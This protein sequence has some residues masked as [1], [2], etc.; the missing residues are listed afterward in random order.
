MSKN[1]YESH[2]TFMAPSDSDSTSM[3]PTGMGWIFSQIDGDPVLGAGVKS[4]FTR[5]FRESVPLESVKAE[6]EQVA[7][8]LIAEGYKILRRKVE[9]VVYDSKRLPDE[10]FA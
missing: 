6:A 4:Y 10:L 5:Q 3:G 1:Y 9:L 7:E 8:V 2:V